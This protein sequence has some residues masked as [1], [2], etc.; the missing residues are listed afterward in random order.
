MQQN[1]TSRDPTVLMDNIYWMLGLACCIITLGSCARKEAAEKDLLAGD[2]R[3]TVDSLMRTAEDLARE[4]L[5]VQGCN[6]LA[7]G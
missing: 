7:D 2:R 6:Q 5:F 1:S 3:N 4:S